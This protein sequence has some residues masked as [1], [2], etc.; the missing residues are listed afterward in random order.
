M[1]AASQLSLR[2]LLAIV[3][4][5]GLG[6]ASLR[7]GGVFASIVN[8]GAMV[9]TVCFAIIAFVG[10]EQL[11]V[12]AIGFLIPV[13]AY[14]GIVLTVGKS[15]L[16]PYEGKLAT[17]Q[18]LRPLFRMIAKPIWTNTLTGEVVP[19]YNP[20]KDPNRGGG[21]MGGGGMGG[22]AGSPMGYSESPDRS[23]F[24][25]LAHVLVAMMF[26]YAGGRFAVA[27]HCRQRDGR[28]RS[29]EQSHPP[30]SAAGPVSNSKASP[31]AK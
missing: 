15:E 14:A 31:L 22:L 13:V 19:D 18:L 2:E 11:R 16:D 17:S 21:G 12:F 3:L 29:D 1:K 8:F 9:L 4:F 7:A 23:T 5:A 10:R 6:L 24:M 30:E 20:A 27:V 28:P 25:S 26:G